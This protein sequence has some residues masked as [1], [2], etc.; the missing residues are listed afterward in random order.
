MAVFEFLA[1]D[2]LGEMTTSAIDRPSVMR[3]ARMPELQLVNAHGFWNI[4]MEQS[5]L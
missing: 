1:L 5:I 4:P 3:K 2:L